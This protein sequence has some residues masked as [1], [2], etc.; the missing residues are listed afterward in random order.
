[1]SDVLTTMGLSRKVNQESHRKTP[2]CSLDLC[3]N[4]LGYS[5]PAEGRPVQF[6]NLLLAFGRVFVNYNPNMAQSKDMPLTSGLFHLER[7]FQ[8]LEC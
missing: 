6:L 7:R 4:T 8:R 1:M 2:S 5:Q 3:R